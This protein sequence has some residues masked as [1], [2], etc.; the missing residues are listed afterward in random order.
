MTNYPFINKNGKYRPNSK[1]WSDTKAN[2][3]QAKQQLNISDDEFRMLSPYE[4]HQGI[5]EK[6]YQTFCNLQ[7]KLR[8]VW[9][10]GSLKFAKYEIAD[11]PEL[12][13][14]YLD[15]LIDND[16]KIW[17]IKTEVIGGKDKFWLYEGK[18]TAM[19]KILAEMCFYEE[20]YFVSKKYQ[21]LL[22]INHHDTLIATGG[23]MPQKLADLHK[24]ILAE[25]K[26]G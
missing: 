13:E 26:Q 10:W 6:I 5:Q 7:G 22:A 19:Q 11:T 16:E 14:T 25:S 1:E 3:M 18:I 9:I 23:D 2:I 15:K 8:P 12:P 4:N 20:F 21:W 17:F 24:Q